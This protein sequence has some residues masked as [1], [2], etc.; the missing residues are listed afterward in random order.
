MEALIE[1]FKT[2]LIANSKASNTIEVYEKNMR[3]FFSKTGIVKLEDLTEEKVNEYFAKLRENASQATIN[4]SISALKSFCYY[5]RLPIRLPKTK[6]PMKKVISVISEDVFW[7]QIEPLIDLN[8]REALRVKAM[9]GFLYYCGLRIGDAVSVKREQFDLAHNNLLVEIEKQNIQ[10]RIVIPN[11][12][13]PLL[14]KYFASEVQEKTAFNMSRRQV[15]R[16]FDKLKVLLPE[17]KLHP[18]KFRKSCATNAKKLGMELPEIKSMM[19]HKDI[20]TTEI[21]VK[22]DDAVIH[23][24]FLKLEAEKIKKQR[25]EAK[26]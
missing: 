19:G 25:K 8:W 22:E 26:Q 15:Q 24:K 1:Q 12:Y 14:T 17:L 9:L 10:K 3:A 7:K 18:H 13:L 4:Q 2:W 5:H 21:Y 20:A 16:V 23:Q 6:M 11:Q